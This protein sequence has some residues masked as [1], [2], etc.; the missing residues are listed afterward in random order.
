MDGWAIFQTIVY[1]VTFLATIVGFGVKISSIIQKN[2]DA[3]NGLTE[4]LNSISNDNKK[5]HDNFYSSINHLEQDVAVLKEK[6]ESDIRLLEEKTR[7]KQIKKIRKKVI[8]NGK[9]TRIY[10]SICD[11][12]NRFNLLLCRLCY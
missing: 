10:D 7:K 11:F 6:H 2:T 8:Q 3:I 5:D 9:F 12:S 1:I 4:K